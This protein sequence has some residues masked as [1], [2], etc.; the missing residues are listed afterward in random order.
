MKKNNWITGRLQRH[1]EDKGYDSKTP[2]FLRAFKTKQVGMSLLPCCMGLQFNRVLNF[3][4]FNTVP[5]SSHHNAKYSKVSVLGIPPTRESQF[6]QFSRRLQ[7]NS[8]SGIPNSFRIV[9]KYLEICSLSLR[10]SSKINSIAQPPMLLSLVTLPVFSQVSWHANHYYFW[11]IQGQ[12]SLARST[13]FYRS[14]FWSFI[15][16]KQIRYI[17]GFLS[18]CTNIMPL[19]WAI[20]SKTVMI[21]ILFCSGDEG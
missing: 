19:I 3:E 6:L 8:A 16:F 14:L 4:I 1:R 5:H 13:E 17:Y 12:N 15:N 9:A 21:K 10:H 7:P 20:A 2:A 11:I 18:I